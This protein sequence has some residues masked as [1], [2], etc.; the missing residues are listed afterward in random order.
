MPTGANKRSDLVLVV[1]ET[2]SR[3]ASRCN[4]RRSPQRLVSLPLLMLVAASLTTIHSESFQLQKFPSFLWPPNHQT[5]MQYNNYDSPLPASSKIQTVSSVYNSFSDNSARE[6]KSSTNTDIDS[7]KHFVLG[8]NNN[9]NHAILVQENAHQQPHQ[10]DL[11]LPKPQIQQNL[12]EKYLTKPSLETSERASQDPDQM[13][14]Q[15]VVSEYKEKPMIAEIANVENADQQSGT[16]KFSTS[17]VDEEQAALNR[18]GSTKFLE[19]SK[20]FDDGGYKT[21]EKRFGFFKKGQQSNNN[22]PSYSAVSFYDECERCLHNIGIGSTQSASW[23]PDSLPSPSSSLY[24]QH[25]QLSSAPQLV[26]PITNSN[27][28][29]YMHPLGPYKNKFNK[30]LFQKPRN[31]GDH[32]FPKSYLSNYKY[33]PSLPG[34]LAYRTHINQPLNCIQPVNSVGIS[35]FMNQGFPDHVQLDDTK[36]PT[37]ASYSN[38]VY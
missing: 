25:Q 26:Y 16:S 22:P 27:A 9:T 2:T 3:P 8:H 4:A 11:Y 10:Q 18:A 1:N 32:N 37:Q 24:K 29:P 34:L 6:G 30:F 33:K 12:V 13:Q 23:L 19:T 14:Y 31:F 20:D 21:L 38:L 35:P 28:Q 15:Y 5:Q 17:H 7:E 36:I